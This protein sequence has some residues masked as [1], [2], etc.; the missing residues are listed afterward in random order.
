[1][2]TTKR[3]R[4]NLV[5][6]PATEPVTLAEV[7]A[8]LKI[9][10]TDEDTLLTTLITVARQAVE[11]YTGRALITQTWQVFYDRFPDVYYDN[12]RISESG[13]RPYNYYQDYGKARQIDIKKPP[14]LSITHIKTYANDDTATIFSASSY[15]VSTYS[16]VAPT[17]GRVTLKDGVSFP[18]FT[19]NSDGIEI[20]FVAGY[21]AASDV[22][23]Q[24]KQ[25]ILTL[26]AFIY[27]N[28]GDCGTCDA[29]IVSMPNIV[30]LMLQP[31]KMM[32]L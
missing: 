31:F 16:G 32:K 3:F 29:G 5:T 12:C 7:K 19:R 4:L 14:L 13:D 10:G 8:H 1:M 18:Y 24:L 6:A 17:Y 28:R 27:E 11:D 20:Q 30:L 21:G 26:I 15:Q 23:D 25:A 22:P 2:I 9:D